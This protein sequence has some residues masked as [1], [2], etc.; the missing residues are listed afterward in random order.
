MTR[1]CA[2][3]G[4]RREPEQGAKVV[5]DVQGAA[6]IGAALR[7]SLQNRPEGRDRITAAGARLRV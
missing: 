1:V 4:L 2:G 5:R 7:E 6:A 3:L